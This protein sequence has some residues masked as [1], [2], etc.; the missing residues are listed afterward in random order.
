MGT[1]S[2]AEAGDEPHPQ[3]WYYFLE[4]CAEGCVEKAAGT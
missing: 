4:A 1:R 3:E 2:E